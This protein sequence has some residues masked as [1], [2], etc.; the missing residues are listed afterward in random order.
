MLLHSEPDYPTRTPSAHGQS[1]IDRGYPCDQYRK[2]MI[3]WNT[4][5]TI[6]ASESGM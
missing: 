5:N 2:A 4:L 6:K 1:C 3:A